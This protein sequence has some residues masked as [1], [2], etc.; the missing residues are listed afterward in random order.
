MVGAETK[1]W[2]FSQFSFAQLFDGQRRLGRNRVISAIRSYMD[3]GVWV[4]VSLTLI[5]L[6]KRKHFR[7]F[8]LLEFKSSARHKL[9]ASQIVMKRFLRI[10]IHRKFT[11]NAKISATIKANTINQLGVAGSIASRIT[12]RQ[13]FSH[14]R[15]KLFSFSLE[16][17]SFFRRYRFITSLRVAFYCR[18]EERCHR[19]FTESQTKRQRRA[20]KVR[21]NFLHKFPARIIA[22]TAFVN[23]L[24]IPTPA[25]SA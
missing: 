10:Y 2:R 19:Q 3:S 22:W 21:H 17:I 20:K 1:T 4:W 8:S 14:S 12:V 6:F 7:C 25:C 13:S 9:T 5:S 24:L 15:R 18:N 16:K 23:S 11:V